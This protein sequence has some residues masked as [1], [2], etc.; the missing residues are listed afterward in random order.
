[1][2][3]TDRIVGM[4][5]SE[6][7]SLV[8]SLG[9]PAFRGKQIADWV[10]RKNAADISEMTNLPLSLRN[11]LQGK[12]E[13]HHGSVADVS[14]A[15]DGT[16]K[17]L[18]SLDFG[19]SI[20]AVLLPYSERVTACVSTQAG[21][22]VG[23][24]FCATGIHGLDR[25][26]TAGEMVDEVLIL[27]RDSLRRVSHVVYMGMGEPLLNYDNAL[28]SIHLLNDEVGIAMRHITVSTVGI[29]PRIKMLAK[30]NLQITLAISLHASNDDTRRKLI[31]IAVRFPLD[32]LIPVCK[33]YAQ[34]TGRRITFE[35]M[36]IKD[37]ND[38]IKAAHELG[39]LLRGTLSNVNL[40]PYNHVEGLPYEKPTREK[41]DIFRSTLESVGLTVTQRMER[42]HSV[43]AACGQLRS[44]KP[45]D[46]SK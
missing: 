44:R 26:L 14:K 35:Y 3:K 6:L 33:D 23:C 34:S 5:T 36:L 27:Q 30:E 42:G 45:D 40:I 29:T 19:H 4:K 43:A 38:S 2:N 16:V 20:E 32:E 22:G 10:Y 7:E 46:A 13:V 31:P 28:A 37:V 18:L 1:M 9:Q 8:V 11:D 39:K 24:R 12:M 15:K 21:C 41:I 17:Y 25:N